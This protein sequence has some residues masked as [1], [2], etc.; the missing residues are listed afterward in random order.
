VDRR[1]LVDA[2]VVLAC[3]ALTVLAVKTPWS[4]LPRAVIAVAGGL[5]SAAQWPRRRWPHVAAVAGAAGFALSGNP[6][7]WLVGLYSAAALAPRRQIW[8]PGLAGWAGFLAWSWIDA[9]RL[10]LDGAGAA[11]LG[12]GLVIAA[13]FYWA[14]RAA[15]VDA[16]RAQA[17][18]AE[19]ERELR[20]ERARGAERTRIAREMHDVL[21]HRLSLLAVHAGALEFRPD[22]PAGQ[23]SRAAAVVRSCAYQ[24]LE[25]LREVIGMLRDDATDSDR[26]QPTLTD[27]PA[28]IEQS[29]LAGARITLDSRSLPTVP[30]GIG[31]HAYR[32]VQE[33]LTNARK[34]APGAPVTVRVAGDDGLVVEV[35]NT[36]PERAPTPRLPGA[37]SGLIGLRERMKLVGGRLE[38]DRTPEGEFRLY[39]WLP[40]RP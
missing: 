6:G 4:P 40:L 22:A 33:G 8:L 15:L 12:V 20:E 19:T 2:G 14:T 5:A 13:G 7:P 10:T 37:G 35:T 39:A 36:L 25:D 38:H 30:D 9:G 11:A 27:L 18:R 28:L 31:R 29:H 17:L 26:P 1:R 32:I 23:A 24:A 34:H 21:A 16:L 3:L